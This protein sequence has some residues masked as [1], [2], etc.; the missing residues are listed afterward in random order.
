[1]KMT[2][3]FKGRIVGLLTASSAICRKS[4]GRWPSISTQ[5]GLRL[6]VTLLIAS[7]VLCV[8]ATAQAADSQP[9]ADIARAAETF[10]HE[11]VGKFDR[12]VKLQAGYLDPRLRLPLCDIGLEPFLRR[13]VKIMSR[14]V[15]GVRCNGSRPWKIYVPVDVVVTESL[16]VAKNALPRGHILTADDVVAED[17]DISRLRGGY[18][19]NPIKLIGQR[20]KHPIISGSIITPAM[21][22]PDVVIKRGQSVTLLV[23]SGSLSISMAG[24]ALMDGAVDQRIKVSVAERV[25]E[26][27]VR[28]SEYVEIPMY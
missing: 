1:M 5:L 9:T 3:I 7:T 25:V 21:V 24:I 15:V 26:G 28:S 19:S 17:R 10:L 18:I 22:A 27:R 13:G 8:A 11:K 20:L 4:G 23:R 6:Y 14:T 12:R 2:K 16:L